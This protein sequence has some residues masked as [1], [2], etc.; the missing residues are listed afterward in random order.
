MSPPYRRIVA[1]AA[2]V[3][4]LLPGLVFAVEARFATARTR[5]R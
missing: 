3:L 2:T 4:I 5:H 1:V